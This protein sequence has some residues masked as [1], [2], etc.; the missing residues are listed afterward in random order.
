LLKSISGWAHSH[1][2]SAAANPSGTLLHHMGQLVSQQLLTAT[3]T[4]VIFSLLKKNV[5]AGG[6]SSGTQVLI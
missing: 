6:K 3:G 2:A 5:L 1:A 4:G